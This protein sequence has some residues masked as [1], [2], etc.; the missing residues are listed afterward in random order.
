VTLGEL[1]DLLLAWAG[2][3]ARQPWLLE[4]RRAYFARV[5]EP[6]E[7]DKSYEARMNGLIDH[8]LFDFRP[9]GH[10][11]TLALYLR[12]G[13]VGL[14]TDERSQMREMGR[15]L[16]LLVEVRKIRPGVVEVEDVFT[17]ARYDVVER[18][19]VVALSKGDIFE[20]RLVPHEGKLHFSASS[21]Y[22]PREV[23]R[24]ILKEAKRRVEDAPPGEGPDVEEF[25]ATLSRM[26]LRLERYRNVRVE[27]IY[28]FDAPPGRTAG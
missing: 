28:D 12:D 15:N 6:H 4:A 24:A 1:H 7:E 27:S 2:A 23:R 18:R 25:L 16:H 14:T 20:T 21:I 5:G 19:A 22:H 10:E 8:Y 11:T 9:D 26:A 17:E 3:E 13:G